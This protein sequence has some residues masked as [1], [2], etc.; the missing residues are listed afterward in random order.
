MQGG[1]IASKKN[2]TRSCLLQTQKGPSPV[3]ITLHLLQFVADLYRM[4]LL[5]DFVF[6]NGY[7][8]DAREAEDAVR[9][10]YRTFADG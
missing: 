5:Y 8:L 9:K 4:Q 2:R 6:D 7:K 1:L 10:K 3:L